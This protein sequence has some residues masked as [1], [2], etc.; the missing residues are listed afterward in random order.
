[1]STLIDR[2]LART[3]HP[4]PAGDRSGR[5]AGQ[6]VADL[7]RLLAAHADT[8]PFEDLDSASATPFS[9]DED[10]V[11]AKL[12]DARRGGYCHEHA[13]LI[14]AVLRDMGLTVRPVLA[15]VY[16]RDGLTEVQAFGH[17]AT[18][19]TLPSDADAD[20]ATPTTAATPAPTTD[21]ATPAAP[22][23]PAEVLVDPGFGGGT[24]TVAVPLDGTVRDSPQGPFRVVP[25][26]DAIDPALV[27]GLDLML[28]H[29]A[30]G[31]AE[32][33]NVYAFSRTAVWEPVDLDMSHWLTSARPGTFFTGNIVIARHR[34]DGGRVTVFQD[35]VHRVAPG[36][37]G[38]DG[39]PGTAGEERRERVGSP[40]ELAG[41]LREEFGLGVDAAL[42]RAA[43]EHSGAGRPAH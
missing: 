7:D 9:V 28:Q 31:S 43:W 8:I 13:A 14:R 30:F 27:R 34:P 32:F 33:A 36:V 42:V 16:A 3:G 21:P 20:A 17:Q 25:A 1:M 15:R 4:V 6:I 10:A 24:P 38:P 39:S 22:R 19:V 23:G 29:R 26:A 5:T 35:T 18:I 41:V 12:V 11:V 40:E 2:Y 37:P